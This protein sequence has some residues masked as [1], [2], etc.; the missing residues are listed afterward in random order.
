MSSMT[1]RRLILF[2]AVGMAALL[3]AVQAGAGSAAPAPGAG[4]RFEIYLDNRGGYRWRLKAA[5][6]RIVATSGEGYK[7]KAS[8]RDAIDLVMRGAATATIQDDT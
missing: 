7:T 8:C 3:P 1:R 5:N 2:A 4:L 6:G